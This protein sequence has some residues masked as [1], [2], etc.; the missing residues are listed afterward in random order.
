MPNIVVVGAQWGD[1]GK[2]KIVDLLMGRFDLVVRYQGGHNAGHTVSVDGRKIV[3]HLIPSGIV[4]PGKIC[5]IGNGVVVDLQ[6]FGAEVSMLE[7]L[8]I[9][10]DGRLFVSDRAHLILPY[11]RAQ[12]KFEEEFRGRNKIDTTS[13]GIGPTYEDKF[14]RRGLRV[15]DL[16]DLVEFHRRLQTALEAK[17]R[18]F[19]QLKGKEHSAGRILEDLK[20]CTARLR[21]CTIDAATYINQQMD[22][23]KT[24]LFEG[25]QGALL[26]V[27]HGTYPFVTSSSSNAAG[28]CIGAGVSPRRING[29]LGVAK[30]Y[31]TRVGAGPFPTES[32]NSDGELL[33][34]RG[35]EF[36]ASTGRARRCGWFDAV[37]MRY[38][39]TLNCFDSLV[40]TKMDVLDTLPE[41]PVCIGYTYRGARVPGFPSDVGLLEQCEPIYDSRPGWQSET[42]GLRQYD[43]LPVTARD[44]L[45]YLE[46]QVGVEVGLI[47]TGVDREDTILREDRPGLGHLLPASPADPQRAQ[48][49]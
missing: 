14:G 47:S 41:I 5:V 37:A 39:H 10:V 18:Y 3:L 11:H 8:N 48:E 9:R 45:K 15:G 42:R 44:Y 22:D 29:I 25:A 19:P 17:S 23:G 30:A 33:R 34:R 38:A 16:A 43:Q 1:E 26:D 13:R 7:D 40:I 24:V 28:A 4:R 20:D 12:E 6:A 31:C 27:D 36:G 49:H 32:T 46:E 35:G 21:E 2:G